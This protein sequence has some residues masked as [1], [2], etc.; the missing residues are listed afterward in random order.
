MAPPRYQP[1]G[2]EATEA[3]DVHEHKLPWSKRGS[4][5]RVFTVYT[6][7]IL[8][9]LSIAY[10]IFLIDQVRITKAQVD[11]QSYGTCYVPAAAHQEYKLTMDDSGSAKKCPNT[12][13]P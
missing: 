9:T 3:E 1:L 13:Y 2:Q 5:A 8:L 11:A 7:C 6:L 10:N 12:N 4:W